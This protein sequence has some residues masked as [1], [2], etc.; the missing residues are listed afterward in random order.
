[1]P[2]CVDAPCRHHAD[3]ELARH[4][5]CFGHRPH[6]DHEA[7]AVLAVERG[8]DR[9]DAL[10]RQVGRRVDQPGPHPFEVDRQATEAVGVD[11]AQVGADEAAGDGRGI[12]G[13]H[14]MGLQQRTRE[15]VCSHRAGVHALAARQ[16]P[17]RPSDL[18]LLDL[19]APAASRRRAGT[20]CRCRSR[21][22]A[23]PSARTRPSGRGGSRV[24]RRRNAC[25]ACGRRR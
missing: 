21:H 23:R 12:L 4:R 25:R 18:D 11:A 6:P 17:A 9:S 2:K 15:R 13:R 14:A 22:S 24:R 19:P 5:D 16:P 7:E 1:M 20:R 8:C 3:A 10:R